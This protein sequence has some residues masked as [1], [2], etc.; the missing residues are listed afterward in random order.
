MSFKDKKIDKKLVEHILEQGQKL[1]TSMI[2]SILKNDPFNKETVNEKCYNTPRSSNGSINYQIKELEVASDVFKDLNVCENQLL[3]ERYENACYATEKS[4]VCSCSTCLAYSVKCLK[5]DLRRAK[6]KD[7]IVIPKQKPIKKELLEYG[8]CL[9]IQLHSIYL[10][11]QGLKKVT[12]DLPNRTLHSYNETYILEYSIPK[13]FLTKHRKSTGRNCLENDNYSRIIGRRTNDVI[14]FKRTLIHNVINISLCGEEEWCINFIIKYKNS[15]NKTFQLLGVAKFNMENLIYKEDLTCSETL[16]IYLTEKSP[17][18][19]GTLKL[20]IQLGCGRVFFGK[21][22]I[23]AVNFKYKT[24]SVENVKINKNSK[25]TTSKEVQTC[26]C[27]LR[28][29]EIFCKSSDDKQCDT[30]YKTGYQKNLNSIRAVPPDSIKSVYFKDTQIDWQKKWLDTKKEIPKKDQLLFGF[31][32]ISEAQFSNAVC[33]SYLVC[34]PFCQSEQTFSKIVYSNGNPVY[35]FYQIVPLIYEDQILE[36][37]RDNF[38]S[39][40]FWEKKQISSRPFG[41]SSVPLHQFYIAYRNSAIFPHLQKNKLPIIG[42]DWWEPIN[43]TSD[44][45][46]IG[47]VHVLTALGTREQITNL[48]IERGFKNDVVRAKFPNSRK[49]SVTLVKK[50]ANK[51]VAHLKS[52]I[53]NTVLTSN[54]ENLQSNHNISDLSN[55][56]DKAIQSDFVPTMDLKDSPNTT[57]TQEILCNFLK[58]LEQKSKPVFMETSTN[59]EPSITAPTVPRGLNNE[60][61]TG[62]SCVRKTSDLLDTLQ[63]AISLEGQ[64]N[65]IVDQ[66]ANIRVAVSINCANQ[67][68]NRR[69]LK[70]KCKRIKSKSPKQDDNI[71]PSTYVTFETMPGRPVEITNVFPKST[72]PQWNYKCEV[73]LPIDMITNDQKRLIFKV[74]KK[75]TN[76]VLQ[77]NTQTDVVLGFAAVDLSVLKA[78]LPSIQG[79]F[80]IMDFSGK[81][82]GQINIHIDP[83]ENVQKTFSNTGCNIYE[84]DYKMQLLPTLTTGIEDTNEPLNRALKRKFTELD[85]ITQRLR[86]RL[87][88]VVQEDS[89]ESNDDMAEEFENDINN[90]CIEEDFD[91]INFE[92]EARKFND[93]YNNQKSTSKNNLLCLAEQPSGAKNV[94]TVLDNDEKSKTADPVAS[95][96]TSESSLDAE[97]LKGKEKI[98]HL[99]KK[100]TLATAESQTTSSCSLNKD[101]AITVGWNPE[102]CDFIQSESTDA[103]SSSTDNGNLKVDDGSETSVFTNFS[104]DNRPNPDGQGSSNDL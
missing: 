23:D 44:N 24:S 55:K 12:H 13:I 102:K 39:I 31:I 74:W 20:T 38:I 57:R 73:S 97:L 96:C 78:G 27:D 99:L 56:V 88:E 94:D 47:Q 64:Q 82:N 43:S 70:S 2:E 104:V 19:I 3:S 79:W 61:S 66:A 51:N 30:L 98:D 101:S 48:E 5:C 95:N 59:T 90:L 81:C 92:E 53:D 6:S 16:P 85:E 25:H 34:Q 46:V 8:D 41:I 75:S 62:T 65:K 89:E 22:F 35:N 103:I 84:D 21:E 11:T 87:S 32:Y 9:K 18:V 100:L 54:K 91:L 36:R 86:S 80:N 7:S 58:H 69:K 77:P 60:A 72:A 37:L 50:D 83:L 28:G 71:M 4:V 42:T 52:N 15:I 29:H 40:E 14:P 67:L 49:S 68:P 33:D 10:N 63:K 93:N 76:A 1:R 26:K 45:S 17:I